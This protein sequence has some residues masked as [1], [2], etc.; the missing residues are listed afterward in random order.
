MTSRL[1]MWLAVAAALAGVAG[2]VPTAI[3]VAAA[4]TP[5]DCDLD[6]S[7][8]QPCVNIMDGTLAMT[9]SAFG[10]RT[11][12]L[13]QRLNGPACAKT[14]Y[15]FYVTP[16]GFTGGSDGPANLDADAAWV[17]IAPSSGDGTTASPQQFS[18][19]LSDDDPD[20]C[21][22]ADVVQ[23]RTTYDVAP[24]AGKCLKLSFVPNPADLTTGGGT[25]WK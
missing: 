24:A 20:V 16:D 5:P 25:Y 17:S 1:R 18:I 11:V 3:P 9:G 10:Q 22:W 13:S 7:P 12:T 4:P 6:P 2:L 15:A 14:A 19:T 23:K 21:V 8:C